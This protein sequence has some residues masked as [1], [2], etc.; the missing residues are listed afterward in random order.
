MKNIARQYPLN[1]EKSPDP[2]SGIANHRQRPPEWYSDWYTF[3]V[4]QQEWDVF[5]VDEVRAWIDSLDEPTFC[6]S[7]ATRRAS[8]RAGINRPSRSPSNGTSFT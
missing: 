6:W 8:G 2:A 3:S 7:P 1:R 4:V 5:V